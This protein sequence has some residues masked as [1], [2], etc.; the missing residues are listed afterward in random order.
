MLD[1]YQRSSYQPQQFAVPTNSQQQ[2]SSIMFPSSPN[3]AQSRSGNQQQASSSPIASLLPESVVGKSQAAQ[4][5]SSVDYELPLAS[6]TL[7][8]DYSALFGKQQPQLQLQVGQQLQ[9]KS[10]PSTAAS[11]STSSSGILSYFGLGSSDSAT[12]PVKVDAE[13]KNSNPSASSSLT[14]SIANS[15]LVTKVRSMFKASPVSASPASASASA[16]A[17]SPLITSSSASAAAPAPESGKK[18][19]LMQSLIKDSNFL[20]AFF[21]PSRKSP[22]SSSSQSNSA[23]PAAAASSAQ[24]QQHQFAERANQGS[25]L[26]YINSL[27][28]IPQQQQQQ[29]QQSQL[30]AQQTAAAS[31]QSTGGYSLV[32][33]TER[34]AHALLDSI[35][36]ISTPRHAAGSSSMARKSPANDDKTSIASAASL[37]NDMVSGYSNVATS[38]VSSNQDKQSAISQANKQLQQQSPEQLK[39]AVQKAVKE[40][41]VNARSDVQGSISQSSQQQVSASAP[42]PQSSSA[43]S[44]SESLQQASASVSAVVSA[45]PQQ[46]NQANQ[47]R[48]HVRKTRSIGLDYPINSQYQQHQ[49]Q[50]QVDQSQLVKPSRAAQ[51]NSVV[52]FVADSYT[53]NKLLFN[54][55]MSQVGLAN[56]VPYVDQILSGGEQ[57]VN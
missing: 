19:S 30:Q 50:Q 7:F 23:N 9:P 4:R 21:S 22:A 56:A 13:Q 20:P 37:I 42:A 28:Y 29:Q 3:S 44:N 17:P 6:R 47:Q 33:A 48:E 51:I 18:L 36:A 1:N 8:G 5:K 40:S 26:H 27:A 35:Q 10:S 45:V 32:K 34:I 54:L 46:D 14:N 15:Y 24:A 38:S 43:I 52:D 11:S 25:N 12:S 39:S 31:K 2:S 49:Y 53:N 57:Q 16:S 55:V 41:Q